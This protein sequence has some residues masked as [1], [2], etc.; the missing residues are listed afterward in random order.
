MQ[1]RGCSLAETCDAGDARLSA[2]T[3]MKVFEK[4]PAFSEM[5]CTGCDGCSSLVGDAPCLRKVS[6]SET[7]GTC[8]GGADRTR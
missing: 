1:S 7:E 5:Q 4:V 8:H 3:D 6:M 2:R